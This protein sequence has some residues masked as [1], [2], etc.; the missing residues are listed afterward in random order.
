VERPRVLVLPGRPKQETQKNK[1]GIGATSAVI[2]RGN[3]G[4]GSKKR[5]QGQPSRN[6]V[7]GLK[8]K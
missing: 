4:K 5:T 7:P 8:K 1:K 3:E 6:I 2:R